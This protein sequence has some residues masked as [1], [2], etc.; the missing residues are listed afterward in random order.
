MPKPGSSVSR[1]DVAP[2]LKLGEVVRAFDEHLKLTPVRTE[3]GL[4]LQISP[5]TQADI[6]AQSAIQ[7]RLDASREAAKAVADN[8][9]PAP[10][11][12]M[13]IRVG[14]N[15]QQARLVNQ[16]RPVYPQ[17]AK[18]AKISGIVSLAAL[19]G[20]DGKMKQLAA[21]SGQPLLITAAM[22]A[23]KQWE[24][25]PTFLNGK[26]VEVVTNINVNFTLSQ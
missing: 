19:I 14:G 5:M 12:T 16:A 11:G 26:P 13:R 20:V 7:R 4:I 6:E 10:E 3:D 23:V 22:E 25:Q 17:L 24:Y 15:V 9:P 21:V 1:D 2:F 8:F 18:D